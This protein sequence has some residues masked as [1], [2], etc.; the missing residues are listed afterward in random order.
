[1]AIL[2]IGAAVSLFS[3]ILVLMG[4]LFLGKVQFTDYFFVGI[5]NLINGLNDWFGKSA[6]NLCRLET[7]NDEWSLVSDDGSL[8]SVIELRGSLTIVGEE[9]FRKIMAN[10]TNILN[11]RMGKRGY[12]L[13]IIMQYDPDEAAYEISELL[14]AS[15][16]TARNLGMAL[17]DMMNEWESTI[18]KWC[19]SEHVY[20]VVWTHKESLAPVPLKN[21]K[22]DQTK[23]ILDSPNAAGCQVIARGISRIEDEHRASVNNIIDG[24]AKV[25]C[26]AN[27]VSA[28]DTLWI[29]RRSIDKLRT[30]RKWRGILPGDPLPQMIADNGY[31]DLSGILY[32]KVGPQLYPRNCE[33]IQDNLLMVGRDTWHGSILMNRPPQTPEAFNAFFKGMINEKMPW[34]ASFLLKS[35]GL[36]GTAFKQFVAS[37]LHYTSTNNKKFNMAI[38]TLKTKELMGSAVTSFQAS[39]STSLYGEHDEDK[40][41]KIMSERLS[42]LSSK[43]QSWGS[44]DVRDVVGDAVVGLNS[45]LPGMMPTSPAAKAAG[46]LEEI[47]P[48]MPL[49]RPTSMWEKG[50][51]VFRT[52]DGK[53]MPYQIGSSTQAAW[54]DLGASPM[55]GG[56]SV[57]LNALNFAFCTQEGLSRLPWLSVLDIGPSSS[58]IIELI[59][60]SLP[61][62]KKYLAQYH[63]LRMEDRYSINPF[64]LPL[65]MNRP[66]PI[67]KSYLVNLLSLFATAIGEHSPIEGVPEIARACIDAIYAEYSQELTPKTYEK[68]VDAEVDALVEALNV[69]L[70]SK[71]SWW[72][73]RDALF[74]SGYIHHAT[75]AQRFAVP[76]LSEVAAMAKQEKVT[77]IYRHYTPNKELVTDY[78][79]RKCVDTI[80]A[81]P[82]LKNP[83]RFDF[84]DAKI[85]S[86]DL[87]EV[88]PKGGPEADRQTAVMYMLGRHVV[89]SR[90]YLRIEDAD[91]ADERYRK[92]QVEKIEDMLQDPKRLCYDEVH[93]VMRNDSISA[94]VVGE[95]EIVSRES[96]KWK[97]SLGI[98]SQSIEDF[99]EIIVEMATSLYILGVGTAKMAEKITNLFG[100]NQTAFLEMQRLGI[101]DERGAN[102]IGIFKGNKGTSVH[103]LTNTIGNQALWAFESSR[104]SVTVRNSLYQILGVEKTLKRLAKTYPNGIKKEIDRRKSAFSELNA[105]DVLNDILKDLVNEIAN[106]KD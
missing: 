55:G 69:H 18:A 71:T 94:Q 83:T 84:G 36:E 28:H 70:D 26:V 59:R 37:I 66:T 91:I 93:R 88:A 47:I 56:K 10:T 21:S 99:P 9:E 72:E 89:A 67:H 74:D 35:K 87:D 50:N 42:I 103:R 33:S 81:Y 101:P 3:V 86:L 8:V 95:M 2:L 64:D 25:G 106:E 54:I 61:E 27:K 77:G 57:L 52:S 58:G 98:Y 23:G 45:T 5:D 32:P 40:A 48:M 38:D 13:Q 44:S 65:G 92:W 30:G 96:R 68:R 79:W 76:L 11:S 102:F 104:E 41:K 90:F 43:V 19:A 97:L 4:G 63:K 17:D 16:N 29:L 46:P 51:T 22:A 62:E 78:F 60:A 80:A 31:E 15:R 20:L 82:I 34:R 12:S 7:S 49:T 24:F 73:I 100:L 85:I 75:R 39:F 14:R 1:M 105:D 53:I 6:P